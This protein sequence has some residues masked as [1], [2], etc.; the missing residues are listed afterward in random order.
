MYYEYPLKIWRCHSSINPSKSPCFLVPEW[1]V[2]L[3]LI[4]PPCNRLSNSVVTTVPPRLSHLVQQPKVFFSYL[5]SYRVEQQ[6]QLI[7]GCDCQ[8]S[9]VSGT[10]LCRL[11]VSTLLNSSITSTTRIFGRT[12][13]NPPSNRPYQDYASHNRQIASK[14]LSIVIWLPS[15][16]KLPSSYYLTAPF[17]G[18]VKGILTSRYPSN[19][20]STSNTAR[21]HQIYY[22]SHGKA[23]HNVWLYYFFI[24]L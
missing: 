4:Q 6:R 1:K 18:Y 12:E 22:Y 24:W 11:L 9:A 21:P 5:T 20:R 14:P 8:V 19:Q 10:Y 15:S 3:L 2:S 16:D 23:Q 13:H 7:R 17:W